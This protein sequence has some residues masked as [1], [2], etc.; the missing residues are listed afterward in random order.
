LSWDLEYDMVIVG[1]GVGA[2]TAALAAKDAGL[3]VAVFEKSRL[4][5]GASAITNG[6]VWI[7]YNSIELEEG[8]RDSESLAERYFSALSGGLPVSAQVRRSWLQASRSAIIYLKEEAGL[9]WRVI[10][11][12]PDVLYG[13][14]DSALP[15]GRYLEVEPFDGSVLGSK[16]KMIQI[17]LL[18]PYG[19]TNEEMLNSPS[20]RAYNKANTGK[21]L[22]QGPGLMAYLIYAAFKRKI[23][24]LCGHRLVRLMKNDCKVAGAI[25]KERNGEI[26]VKA[27]HALLLS[28]GGYGWH[29]KYSLLFEHLPE[30]HCLLPPTIE[31]DSFLVASDVGAAYIPYKVV[32]GRPGYTVPGELWFGKPVYRSLI[33]EA[34]YPHSIIVNSSG[35]RFADESNF[36]QLADRS[37]SF[38]RSR[39]F[40]NYPFFFIFDEQYRLKYHLGP[41]GPGEPFPSGLVTSSRTVDGLARKLGIPPSSLV[42][43]ITNFNVFARKGI[44]PEFGRG[45][46]AWS[47]AFAGDRHNRPNPNLGTIETPPFYGIRL[48]YV[49]AGYNAG[50]IVDTEARILNV[51]G[52][53][54]PSLYACGNC[55]SFFDIG[56]IYQDGISL[57]RSMGLGYL[58][59]RSATKSAGRQFHEF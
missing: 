58:A 14:A 20:A 6:E 21:R 10:K 4:I 41:I 17:S 47:R 16:L 53:P 40:T 2:L 29:P 59:A 42:R 27:R 51:R 55:V 34:G 30:W 44:D 48:T 7:P 12:L 22:C 25:I 52:E 5:G 23:E 57:A 19:I 39:G 36:Q 33:N 37:G 13:S 8:F 31:G 1:S 56:P 32:G 54:I 24:I 38:D 9:R 35:M 43:T 50:Y 28:I 26:K 18:V 46:K 3:S 11:G 15:E 49:G 45:T